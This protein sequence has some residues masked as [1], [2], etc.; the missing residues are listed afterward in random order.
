MK[1]NGR[2]EE[3]R[4][5]MIHVG[6]SKGLHSPEVLAISEELDQLIYKTMGDDE[7]GGK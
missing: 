2:I 3:L 6:M 1:S 5:K 4:S 7:N